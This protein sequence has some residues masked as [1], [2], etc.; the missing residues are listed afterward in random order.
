MK[1]LEYV[2][3]TGC[4]ADEVDLPITTPEL[5]AE[6]PKPCAARSE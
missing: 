1:G 5:R 2:I 6:A 4:V 3:K